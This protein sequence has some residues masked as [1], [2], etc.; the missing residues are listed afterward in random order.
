MQLKAPFKIQFSAVNDCFSVFAY[1][2]AVVKVPR[3]RS[4]WFRKPII[5]G[6]HIEWRKYYR[7]CDNFSLVRLLYYH[8]TRWSGK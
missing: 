7:N 3:W 2:E 8:V 5:V 6:Y 1:Q 4:R